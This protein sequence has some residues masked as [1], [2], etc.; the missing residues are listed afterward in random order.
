MNYWGRIAVAIALIIAGGIIN[1]VAM[2][3]Y[4]D[5]H[6]LAAWLGGIAC[7]ISLIAGIVGKV[8]T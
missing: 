8:R 4:A 5:S 7:T 1:L 2:R 6:S 3:V